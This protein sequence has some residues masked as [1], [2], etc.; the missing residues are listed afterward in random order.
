M[1]AVS[2]A[3]RAS[4]LLTVLGTPIP[5]PMALFD[6]LPFASDAREELDDTF[7]IDLPG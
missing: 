2:L 7:D 1:L 6:A 4:L 3:L 5:I